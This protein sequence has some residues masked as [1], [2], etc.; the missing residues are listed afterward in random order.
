MHSPVTASIIAQMAVS[1][2]GGTTRRRDAQQAH[3][4]DPH[5]EAVADR[6]TAYRTRRRGCRGGSPPKSRLA[7]EFEPGQQI[8]FPAELVAVRSGSPDTRM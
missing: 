2:R 8:G 3:P 1:D 6:L 4:S 5:S 7:S